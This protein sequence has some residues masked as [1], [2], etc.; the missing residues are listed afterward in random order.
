MFGLAKISYKWRLWLHGAVAAIV[1]SSSNAVT[2]AFIDPQTFNPFM[3]GDWRKIL[4]LLASSA[5][6][7]FFIYLKTHPLPDPD[8]DSD[9][10]VVADK[11][12]AKIEGAMTGTGDG[13]PPRT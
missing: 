2:A 7:G 13:G 5:I 11:A 1:N 8:K 4:A 3:G 12:V 6:L 9:A 10:Q